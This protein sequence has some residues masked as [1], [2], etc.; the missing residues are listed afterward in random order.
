MHDRPFGIEKANIHFA[1][2]QHALREDEGI[3]IGELL[4][5]FRA[6][7]PPPADDVDAITIGCEQVGV[8]FGIVMIPSFFLL[9][10]EFANSSFVRWIDRSA[11]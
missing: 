11:G 3:S 6:A 10:L 2:L 8:S 5:D 7:F 1:K 9:R 4:L